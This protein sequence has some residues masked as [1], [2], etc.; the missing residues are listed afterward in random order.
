MCKFSCSS[1][2]GITNHYK[3]YKIAAK[4]A[5][6]N[7]N[8]RRNLPAPPNISLLASHAA[9]PNHEENQT[10]QSTSSQPSQSS[11]NLS[12]QSI[13]TS[14]NSQLQEDAPENNINIDTMFQVERGGVNETNDHFP[15]SDLWNPDAPSPSAE[16]ETQF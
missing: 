1:K 15:N 8:S 6:Q 2:A 5:F 3:I 10:S 14:L 7:N 4:K 16:F 11:H 13:P 12:Q 9:W